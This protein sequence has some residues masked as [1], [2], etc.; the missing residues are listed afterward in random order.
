MNKTYTIQGYTNRFNKNAQ[1]RKPFTIVEEYAAGGNIHYLPTANNIPDYQ[2]TDIED[3]F[4]WGEWAQR[5]NP[6]I[7]TTTQQPTQTKDIASEDPWNDITETTLFDEN[8]DDYKDRYTNGRW[9]GFGK[10]TFFI[11]ND[12]NYTFEDLKSAFDRLERGEMWGG[13]WGTFKN[14]KFEKVQKDQNQE[15]SIPTQETLTY[16]PSKRY[17]KSEKQQFIND[18][19][20][21][22]RKYLSSVGKD[23]RYAEYFVAQD[24]LET[25]YGQHYAGNW[26]FG[27]ITKGSWKGSVTSGNDHDASGRKIT[28]QFRNYDSLEQYIQDKLSIL[29]NKRYDIWSYSPEQLYDRLVAGGYAEDPNY[30]NKLMSVYNSL[31]RTASAKTGIKLPSKESILKILQ[32]R[33]VI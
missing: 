13:D 16:T 14:G 4:K 29:G 1:K 32:N 8:V 3:P 17:Q 25:G 11:P 7:T 9:E 19:L 31:F 28:Q 22:Y 10:Y 27:N 24:A 5:S 23:P 6:H 26:N 30:K 33:N 2:S 20:T 18:L 15:V 12:K 21:A